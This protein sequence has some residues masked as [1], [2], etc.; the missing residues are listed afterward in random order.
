VGQGN[1]V[2]GDIAAPPQLRKKAI[3]AGAE[4]VRIEMAGEGGFVLHARPVALD[5]R[6]TAATLTLMGME[7]WMYGNS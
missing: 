5:D 2:Q 1:S 4:G 3:D 6:L 7:R